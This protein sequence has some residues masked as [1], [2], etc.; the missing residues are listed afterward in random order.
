MSLCK[1]ESKRTCNRH[2]LPYKE[3]N[4]KFCCKD[5]ANSCTSEFRSK[6]TMVVN[7][8]C[9]VLGISDRVSGLRSLEFST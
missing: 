3:G 4:A 6:L 8:Y 1:L 9:M 7:I 5:S 2:Y